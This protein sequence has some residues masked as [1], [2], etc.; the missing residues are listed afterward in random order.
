MDLGGSALI[1]GEGS[2]MKVIMG[3]ITVLV[4]LAGVML[5][6]VPS[7]TGQP[8]GPTPPIAT[9]DDNDPS[10][11]ASDD[12]TSDT[13]P[14]SAPTRIR[15]DDAALARLE[16][17]LASAAPIAKQ[18]DRE[19]YEEALAW[20]HEHRPADWPYQE[21]E[22][23]F[24]GTLGTILDGEHR[25]AGWLMNLGLIEIDMVRALDADGDGAITFA[26][27][28]AYSQADLRNLGELDHPF[29]LARIDRNQDGQLSDDERSIVDSVAF[30]RD[31]AFAGVFDR[32]MIN[33][34]DTDND[35][36]LTDAERDAGQAE[37]AQTSDPIEQLEA[38]LAEMDA[39]GMF[40]GPDGQARR[41]EFAARIAEERES[42]EQTQQMAM[43]ELAQPLIEAMIFQD[44]DQEV[45]EKPVFVSP[46]PDT[47]DAD[48][49]GIINDDEQRQFQIATDEYNNARSSSGWVNANDAYQAFARDAAMGDTNRDGLFTPNEWDLHIETLIARRDAKLFRLSYDLDNDGRVGQTELTTFIDWYQAGSL[50]ADS[51]YDGLIDARDLE[52]M[53]T[54]YQNQEN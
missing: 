29:L 53:M 26:E 50:R 11:V 24:L 21:F 9:T 46:Q 14:S 33:A 2:V 4:V 10:R 16:A 7:L 31:G 43:I 39:N 36:E 44:R 51:N 19:R 35:G 20:V 54:N 17:E 15:I 18:S 32:A 8:V 38:Q 41:A 37:L 52:F 12:A 22:A 47:F 40:D 23:R 45:A 27:M 5:F 49:D 6:G 25:A 13:D 42:F 1:C 48:S 30:F 34:W 28:Y 3:V